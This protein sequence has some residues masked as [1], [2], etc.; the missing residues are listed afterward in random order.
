MALY[1]RHDDLLIGGVSET[2]HQED[3][4]QLLHRVSGGIGHTYFQYPAMRLLL[5]RHKLAEVVEHLT[6]VGRV[7]GEGRTV[8]QRPLVH[9]FVELLVLAVDQ[10]VVVALRCQRS[11]FLLRRRGAGG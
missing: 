3:I 10:V 5:M 8:R 11:E 1:H 4:R 2:E 6:A 7:G 9:A